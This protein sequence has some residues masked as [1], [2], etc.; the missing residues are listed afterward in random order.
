MTIAAVPTGPLSRMKSLVNRLWHSPTFTTWGSLTTRLLS[1]VLVLPLVLRKFSPAEVV[2]WQ[3]FATLA[4]LLLLLDFGLAPTFSRLLAYAKG[5]ASI[6]DLARMQKVAP[7]AQAQVNHDTLRSV[8]GT[9]H[10]LYLRCGLVATALLCVGGT[11]ALLKPMTAVAD[12]GHAWIA[13]TVVALTSLAAVWGQVFGSALQGL[14]Q[15][16]VMRRWEILTAAGQITCSFLVLWLNGGLLALVIS[17]QA[18]L[19]FNALR[20]RRLLYNTHPELRN[21]PNQPLPEVMKTLWPAAWRSGIGMLMSN[22]VIQ[23]SGV[24]YSQIAPAGEVAAY[25]LALRIMTVVTQFSSAPFYSKLPRLAELHAQGQRDEQLALAKRGMA[26]SLWVY[27]AGAV[28]VM[29][30]LPIALKLTG[31]RVAFVSEPFWCLMALA[32]LVERVGAMHIQLYSLTNHIVW[33]IA[34]GVTGVLLIV[35]AVLFYRWWG[36]IGL[37]LAMLMVNL[38]FYSAYA[39]RYSSRAFGFGILSFLTKTSFGPL[40]LLGGMSALAIQWFHG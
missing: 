9:L 14:N 22:G 31:S 28:A 40:A 34:N 37:P 8:Y 36:A 30:G 29:W 7:K 21:A 10:W 38:G 35:F 27:A 26:L 4:T 13:W 17:N 3:L 1:V 20:L 16:A 18:W 2:I 24:M 12:P 32:F 19:M 39:I 6:E 5:G 15:I 25:L 33:H 11:V 23:L